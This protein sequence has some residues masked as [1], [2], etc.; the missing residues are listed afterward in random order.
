L[1]PQR[2]AADAVTAAQIII[3]IAATEVSMTFM[4]VSPGDTADIGGRVGRLHVGRGESMIPKS[5]YRFS[6]KIMLHE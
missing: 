2:T 4:I 3:A 6:E 5:G 1:L